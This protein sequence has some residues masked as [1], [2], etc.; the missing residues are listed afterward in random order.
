[1]RT[2]TSLRL[3]AALVAAACLA[4]VGCHP[5]AKLDTPSGFATLDR[6]DDFSYR[7]ASARGVV[8]A[9]RTESNDVAGNAEF[10]TDALDEAMQQKGY[11]RATRKAVRTQKG[12]A[13]TQLQYETS[14]NGREHRYWLTVFATKSKVYVVE[15]A[16]DKEPF[17]K[18]KDT[19]DK[20][21]ASLDASS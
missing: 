19:I 11:G 9:T 21:I 3:L 7:A 12:L 16:G 17:D 14:R 2:M 20:A 4:T 1:M 8:L 13:G 15:A 18:A 5:G 10:W 6:T